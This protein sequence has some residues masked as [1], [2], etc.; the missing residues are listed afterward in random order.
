VIDR[1]YD[2]LGEDRFPHDFDNLDYEEPEFDRYLGLPGMHT[3]K[4]RV[5]PPSRE[6]ILPPDLFKHYSE[7]F[8]SSPGENPRSVIVL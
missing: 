5:A 3:V 2:I 7:E 6:T 8:W 4:K 1:L